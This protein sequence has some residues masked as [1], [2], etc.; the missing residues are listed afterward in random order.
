V[1][2]LSST[3]SSDALTPAAHTTVRADALLVVRASR[4]TGSV[5]RVGG[6][7]GAQDLTTNR[8]RALERL[9]L[10]G[11]VDPR[12]VSEVRVLR[13]PR[14][15]Q[16]VRA[17]RLHGRDPVERAQA[18]PAGIEAEPGRLG[19]NDADVRPPLEDRP[20]RSRDLAGGETPVA[21]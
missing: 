17:D 3:V 10:V 1:T 12:L 5:S 9:D 19:K 6:F 16:G 15:D 4:R 8:K 18:Q 11:K 21:T 2:R 7:E 14:D 13:A 20:Q